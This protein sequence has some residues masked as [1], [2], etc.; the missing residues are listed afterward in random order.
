MGKVAWKET[1]EG[2]EV[3]PSFIHRAYNQEFNTGV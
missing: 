3:A 2:S 1:F